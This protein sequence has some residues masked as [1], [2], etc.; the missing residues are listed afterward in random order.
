MQM[1]YL[2][3][4]LGLSDPTLKS[5]VVG[6]GKSEARSCPTPAP[7]YPSC[8]W[9]NCC[10]SDPRAPTK[11]HSFSG[12]R[13]H[14]PSA[15]DLPL[16]MNRYWQ[17][18]DRRGASVNNAGRAMSLAGEGKKG[19]SSAGVVVQGHLETYLRIRE[20]P[21]AAWWA[22]CKILRWGLRRLG[23]CLRHSRF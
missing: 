18:C 6:G 23:G 12:F 21:I 22:H 20:A 4:S 9:K 2:A 19:S 16:T 13:V 10:S 1:G 3:R 5:A 17:E 11:N 14:Y 8:L 7:R 15:V